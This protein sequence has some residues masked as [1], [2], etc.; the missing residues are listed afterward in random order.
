MK[1]R[2]G[3]GSLSKLLLQKRP[4]F[5]AK[6]HT[7]R[8]LCEGENHPR[9]GTG[10]THS[11]GAQP[12]RNNGHGDDPLFQRRRRRHYPA[13]RARGL[14]VGAVL[15]VPELAVEAAA[16]VGLPRG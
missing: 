1:V 11:E 2:L 16:L 10:H 12:R 15:H 4:R 5:V 8:A 13:P 7:P 6:Y 14:D 3:T 9:R